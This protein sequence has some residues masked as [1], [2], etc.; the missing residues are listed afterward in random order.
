MLLFRYQNNAGEEHGKTHVQFVLAT[1]DS[2][3]YFVLHE[4]HFRNSKSFAHIM[5]ACQKGPP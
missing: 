5:T 3:N 4:R 2:S 1:Q